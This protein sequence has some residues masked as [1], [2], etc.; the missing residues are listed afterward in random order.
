[1]PGVDGPEDERDESDVTLRALPDRFR[2][3][4]DFG[5]GW[6]HDV[7]V[8]GPGGDRPGVVAGEGACP[9]EDVGGPHGYAEFRQGMADPEHP[10][11]DE[12]QIWAE[13]W[14]DGFDLDTA[15]L[16]LRQ[17]AGTVPA[18]VRLV[19]GLATDGVKLTPGGRLPRAIV[20]QVQGRY[21]SWQLTDRL[22]S[23]EDD[24]PPLAALH[25]LL[26]HVGLLRLRH[27]FLGP[28]RAAAEDFEVMRRLRSWFGPDDSFISILAGESLASLVVDGACRTEELAARLLPLLGDR[29]V[30]GQGQP[31]DE[32][33]T[34]QELH[35]LQS[36]L[37]GLDLV[38]THKGAWTAGPSAVWL[39]PRA[40]ALAHLWRNLS[41]PM[42]HAAF[43][44]S[45][46]PPLA[47]VR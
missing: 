42:R 9:P 34:R 43:M 46:H 11:H 31:L 2:Y 45:E 15:D 40:T 4:Y 12:L 21:P 10:E 13:S 32:G 16:L 35:R 33:R 20:R 14:N 19:L 37:F 7:V 27:R 6:E 28:T 8:V 23:L 39:H 22:A 44:R 36:V 17:T 18:P 41:R 29:W 3:L 47:T 38:Q 30:T 1:M 5:D 25:D 26:R 24:L